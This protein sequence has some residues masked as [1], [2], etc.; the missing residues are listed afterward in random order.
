MMDAEVVETAER[1]NVLKSL[2]VSVIPIA[3]RTLC[4]SVTLK[5]T[6]TEITEETQRSKIFIKL[7]EAN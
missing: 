6:Y 4:A 1:L 3:I 7:I 5:R 2:W